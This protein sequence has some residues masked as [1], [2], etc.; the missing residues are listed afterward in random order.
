M[1]VRLDSAHVLTGTR[2]LIIL[3]GCNKPHAEACI[4]QIAGRACQEQVNVN[5]SHQHALE[6]AIQDI[7][8]SA[9]NILQPSLSV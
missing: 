1:S 9:F 8:F 7:G 6:L 4:C 2:Q 3:L 5:L